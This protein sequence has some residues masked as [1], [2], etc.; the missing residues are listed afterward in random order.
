VRINDNILKVLRAGPRKAQIL[1][2][3]KKEKMLQCIYKE[4]K[5]TNPRI[6]KPKARI[7]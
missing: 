6:R 7:G 4:N 3:S 2:V 5:R 1:Y